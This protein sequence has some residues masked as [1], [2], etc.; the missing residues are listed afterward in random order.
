MKNRVFAVILSALMLSAVA[1]GCS[2]RTIQVSQSSTVSESSED[3]AISFLAEMKTKV[4]IGS[5][6]EAISDFELKGDLYKDS[7][8]YSEMQSTY[9]EAKEL[10]NKANSKNWSVEYYVDDFGDYTDEAY[11]YYR[12]TGTF[13]NSAT[14]NSPLKVE[15]LIDENGIFIKLYEYSNSLVKNIYS[16]KS[17]EFTIKAKYNGNITKTYSGKIRPSG[18]RI[19]IDKSV[20]DEILGK[21]A[22]EKTIKFHLVDNDYTISTYDFEVNPVGYKDTYAKYQKVK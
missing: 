1:C 14:D 4:T 18:D 20:T 21:F 12:C 15:F 5:Y 9:E 2:G 7:K 16:S 6:D 3:K 11:I 8:H 13:S 22:L 17:L 19:W 10:K